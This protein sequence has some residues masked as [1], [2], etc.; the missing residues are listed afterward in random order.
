[1]AGNVTVM[2]EGF[3]R[4]LTTQEREANKLRETVG[5]LSK[6]L[7]DYFDTQTKATNT[8]KKAKK[9]EEDLKNVYET[10]TN[11]LSKANKELN[12]MGKTFELLSFT[13]LR[14]FKKEGG[15]TFEYL[16][17]ALTGMSQQVKFMGFE[18]AVARKVMYGFLPPGMFRLFNKLSTVLRVSAGA[19]R[20]FSKDQEKS[21]NLLT[22]MGTGLAKLTRT[23]KQRQ[24]AAKKE[25]DFEKKFSKWKVKN[26]DKEIKSTHKYYKI[27]KQQRKKAAK[28]KYALELKSAA[29]EAK[30]LKDK[31]DE[32]VKEAESRFQMRRL[33]VQKAEDEINEIIR[34][35]MGDRPKVTMGAS[36]IQHVRKEQKDKQSSYDQEF[37]KRKASK[38]GD[39]KNP[40]LKAG[41]KTKNVK[42]AEK[43]YK[44]AKKQ[45]KKASKNYA[46]NR[47]LMK[48]AGK[49]TKWLGSKTMQLGMFLR[50]G[51]IAMLI[52]MASFIGLLIILKMLW[53]SIKKTFGPMKENLIHYGGVILEG[54]M[55]A[56]AGVQLIWS[57]LFGG[58][59]MT[60]LLEG[61][62]LLIWGPLQIIWGIFMALVGTAWIFIYE[63]SKDLLS[64]A[65]DWFFSLFTSGNKLGKWVG[66]IFA[67]AGM[68]LAWWMGAP[69]LIIAGLGILLYKVGDY[70]VN[71]FSEVM[72]KLNPVSALKNSMSKIDFQ[73]PKMASG[74]VSGGGI[75]LV[76]EQGPELVN[77]SKGSR[78]HS[79]A[80]SKKMMGNTVQN[81]NITI[82]AKDTSDAELRRVAEKISKM[83]SLKMNRTVSTMM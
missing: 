39:L 16:D 17:L 74:G 5:E 67:I 65:V 40:H 49:L 61:V 25:Q 54:L 63:F 15:N 36:G 32:K 8:A 79:N 80:E 2:S 43:N 47:P 44:L 7:K 81:F 66:L 4:A 76:G 68:M 77:L 60:D 50:T 46:K 22:L 9:A 6:T 30:L 52:G 71:N 11:A 70:L 56:W 19:V 51:L 82:N 75:T 29:D 48:R 10:R 62:W 1:M 26:G 45:A 34:K 23:K 31:A 72:K 57:A 37:N 53:P 83:V 35:E 78:V 55:D 27:D 41:L 42:T 73:I 12:K 24:A 18:V 21:H 28:E 20:M 13:S 59:S 69:I 33:K 38:T 14:Q 3:T 64:K 58:G